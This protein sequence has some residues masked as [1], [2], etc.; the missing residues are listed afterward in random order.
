MLSHTHDYVDDNG[1]K[2]RMSRCTCGSC[3]NSW[4]V[5]T[6]P[7]FQSRFCPYCGIKFQWYDD[8]HEDF[9]LDGKKR[10]G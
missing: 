8:G 6:G 2:M 5:Q 10:N 1:D 7:E 4:Y 3:D 9:N